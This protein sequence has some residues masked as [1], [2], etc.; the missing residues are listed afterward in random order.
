MSLKFV[1]SNSLDI[2]YFVTD[3][4][5]KITSSNELFKEYTSHIKPNQIDDIVTEQGDL[6]EILTLVSKA[7]TN[8]LTPVRSYFQVKQKN[9]SL[10]WNLFNI[11]F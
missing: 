11:V 9:G 6:D 1:L 8:N 4:S 10:R 7:K 5:G 2:L 3:S